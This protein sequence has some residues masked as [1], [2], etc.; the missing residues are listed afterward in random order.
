MKS[1]KSLIFIVIILTSIASLFIYNLMTYD[2]FWKASFVDIFTIGF[3]IIISFYIVEKNNDR[4]KR[5]DC[6]EHIV[7]EIE[8]LLNSEIIFKMG[9]ETLNY[10]ASCA[11]RIKYLKDANFLDIQE[12]INFIADKFEEIRMLYS[13]HNNS[14]KNLDSVYEDFKRNQQYICD[15][16]NKIRIWLYK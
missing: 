12:D 5:N 9:K 1:V 10:Q 3:A 6:I 14:K 11:N 16:C 7:M 4:R 2:A 13:N 15:K 8:Q